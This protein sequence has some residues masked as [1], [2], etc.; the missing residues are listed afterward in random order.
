MCRGGAIAYVIHPQ[1]G[2]CDQWILDHIVPNMK[3]DGVDDQVCIVLGRAVL[4]A[5]FDPVQSLRIPEHR[6]QDMMQAYISL[7]DRNTLPAGENPVIKKALVIVGE[8]AEVVIDVVDDDNEQDG[9][10]RSAALAL[11]QRNQEVR[12]LSSHILQLRHELVDQRAEYERQLAILRRRLRRIDYNIARIASRPA[13]PL[14]RSRAVAVGTTQEQQRDTSNNATASSGEDPTAHVQ[15]VEAVEEET[16]LETVEETVRAPV[17]VAR[18]GKCPKTLND[19]WH[20]YM[21]GWTGLK[22]AKDFTR[23]ERGKVRHTYSRRLVFW[24][25]TSEMV[26]MGYTAESA[27]DKIYSAY[28]SCGSSVTK[29]INAMMKDRKEQFVRAGLRELTL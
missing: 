11:A 22:P 24:E 20:E 10:G 26:R 7:G 5:L 21:F 14:R 16:P 4:W 8:D 3:T 6:R 19:L 1:S 23:A 15:P 12:L 13:R 27:I 18:L 25:K 28:A 9:G 2:I 17:L 29:I